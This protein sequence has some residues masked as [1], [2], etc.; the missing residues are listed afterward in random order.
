MPVT[1]KPA[2]NLP[3]KLLLVAEKNEENL[4]E[5]EQN[6]PKSRMPDRGLSWHP[7]AVYNLE[8]EKPHPLDGTGQRALGAE[9]DSV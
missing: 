7:H 3:K 8:E 2:P 6:R 5:R 1:W 9:L 4:Q